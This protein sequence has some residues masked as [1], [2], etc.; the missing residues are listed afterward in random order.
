MVEAAGRMVRDEVR[1]HR[2]PHTTTR[3]VL[4]GWAVNELDP[5]SRKRLLQS[6]LAM[7]ASAAGVL[8]VEPLA[9]RAT[10]WWEEWRDALAPL[11][12]R[13]DE[14]RFEIPLPAA[15]AELDREAGFRREGLTAKSLWIAPRRA[16]K[17]EG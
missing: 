3:H 7:A 5:D 12:V 11:G 15:L 4:F 13:S 10:P 17:D 6:V 9:H 2:S 1:G 16:A 14:W 8:V